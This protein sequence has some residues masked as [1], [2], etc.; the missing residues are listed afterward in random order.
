MKVNSQLLTPIKKT[1]VSDIVVDQITVL[2]EN[3]SLKIGDRLP[4]ER[5]MVDQ[6]QVARA[7]VREAMRILEFSGVIEVRPGKGAFVVGDAGNLEGEEGVRQ[8]FSDHATE[9]MAMLE[10]REALERRATR[11][12]AE[13][14][15]PEQ[16]ANIEEVINKAQES[17]AEGDLAQL[18]Y[19]DRKF[20]RL[21]ATASQNQIFTQLVDMVTDAM[22]DPRRSLMRLPGRATQSWSAHREILETIKHRDPDR[23]ERAVDAH[24]QEVRQA[25]VALA[26]TN[27]KD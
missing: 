14:A 12:A 22:V 9:A 11:L 5:D 24:L 2:I 17:I 4:T 15:S 1:R 6:W 26:K 10:V 8:W 18:V 27:L 23:A 7:S 20:H 3:G 13:R 21:V 16:I 19:L 25:I